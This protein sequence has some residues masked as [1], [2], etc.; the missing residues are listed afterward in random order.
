MNLAEF[1]AWL[2]GFKEAVGDAPTPEQWQRITEKLA[3][4]YDPVPVLPA[5]VYPTYPV[6]PIWGTGT[7]Y[8]PRFGEIT[9]RN[10]TVFTATS[11]AMTN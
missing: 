8:V 7:P 4:V 9:C 2:D 3:T 5:P 11:M 1:K 6:T 10:D